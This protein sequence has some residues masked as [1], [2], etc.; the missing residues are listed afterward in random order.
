M[1]QKDNAP[2][3]KSRLKTDKSLEHER[4]KT[5]RVIN[6][7]NT[8]IEDKFDEKI[9][10][11]RITADKVLANTR[12]A[13]DMDK[14]SVD[15]RKQ[16]DQAQI[17]ARSEEDR[18][19]NKE[20]FQKR[21]VAEA[22]LESERTNTDNNLMD[23]REGT[24][25]VYDQTKNALITRDQFLAVV[26]HD[27]KNPLSSVAMGAS[28]LR[29]GLSKIKNSEENYLEILEII[30]RN[31]AHMDRMISDLLDVERMSN[32][33]L[34]LNTRTNNISELL[35]ECMDLFAPIVLNKSYTVSVEASIDKILVE[36]DHDKILQVLSNLVGNA[37]K[38]SPK[39]SAIVLSTRKT[40]NTVEVSVSDNGPGIP[41]EKIN[42][43]FERFS[44]L[45]SDDRR[46]L[47]LGL[48]ISKWIVEAHK[49]KIWVQSEIGKG[50]SFTFSLPMSV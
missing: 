47:G 48:F 24:D 45:K 18:I 16:S 15:E 12:I 10:S 37:L 42:E 21:L 14:A 25:V 43:I 7:K 5:D 23:E 9:R 31:V 44:Q 27:L 8:A 2:V 3:N 11:N 40:E 22:L 46:G 32:N 41:Q 26:S 13:A 20:R 34:M 1:D 49:G 33:K 50:S 4:H 17:V 30:E 19:R 38:F 39:G 36:I 6:T 35:K 28:L 29:A